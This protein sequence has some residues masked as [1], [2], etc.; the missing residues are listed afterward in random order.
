[1]SE[2]N[3]LLARRFRQNDEHAFSTLMGRH[4]SLVFRVCLRILGHRQD[5]ED[6][7][8]ETF[9]RVAKYLH[10]WDSQKPFEPWLVAIAGNRCRS[11]LAAKRPFQ[12][13]TA[14]IEPATSES[15]DRRDA[16][17][18]REELQLALQHIPHC[19]RTAFRLFHEQSMS[20]AEIAVEMDCPLG[21]VKTWVH[22]ARLKI[23][24]QLREREVL[25]GP[26]SSTV[27]PNRSGVRA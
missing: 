12:A 10:R 2:S 9:S 14:A 25:C 21:T 3:A 16:D 18:L 22:R 13:L 23:I 7:T 6:A 19:Q 11:L 4:H 20:Y 8:Q 15:V 27:E 26:E 17:L 5:A 1:M 24:E